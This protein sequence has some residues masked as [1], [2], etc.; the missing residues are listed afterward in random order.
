MENTIRNSVGRLKEA[1]DRLEARACE[2]IREADDPDK[3]A[4]F[5]KYAQT[6]LKITNTLDEA[7]IFEIGQ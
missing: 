6:I 2:A 3:L 4:A 5:W 1:L 7:G